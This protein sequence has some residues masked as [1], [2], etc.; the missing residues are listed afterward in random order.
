MPLDSVLWKQRREG[1]CEFKASLINRVCSRMDKAT[2]IV[3]PCLYSNKAMQDESS[4]RFLVRGSVERN[5]RLEEESICM[6]YTWEDTIVIP[7][8]RSPRKGNPKGMATLSYITRPHFDITKLV[9]ISTLYFRNNWEKA[10]EM[11]Q[12]LRTLTGGWGDGSAVKSTD[13]SS[14]GPEFNSQQ[15]DGGSHPS[16]MGS[17]APFWCV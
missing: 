17:N 15:P 10:G 8:L 7:S 13:C 1:L 11:A 9:F 5:L 4:Q 2:Y 6:R 16:V 3:R 12:C 14:R